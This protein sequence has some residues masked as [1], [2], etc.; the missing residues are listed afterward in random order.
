MTAFSDILPLLLKSLTLWH[1]LSVSFKP[2]TFAETVS[3]SK[4]NTMTFI[5]SSKE[6]GKKSNKTFRDRNKSMSEFEQMSEKPYFGNFIWKSTNEFKLQLIAHSKSWMWLWLIKSRI[7]VL[8]A[9]FASA[10]NAT[11]DGILNPSIRETTKSC[12][13]FI[14]RSYTKTRETMMFTTA[15]SIWWSIYWNSRLK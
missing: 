10:K 7:R 12:S 2:R 1:L 3:N 5:V 6:I 13:V 11:F 8:T 14:V 4:Q 9:K 15:K